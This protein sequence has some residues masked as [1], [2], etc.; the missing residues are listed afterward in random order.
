M[1]LVID[2]RY[3]APVHV[4]FELTTVGMFDSDVLHLRPDPDTPFRE[5]TEAVADRFGTPPYEGRHDEILPHVTVGKAIPR[6]R[7]RHAARALMLAM[8]LRIRCSSVA[9]TS[10]TR[11]S[12]A[13]PASS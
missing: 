6:P 5:L 9:P 7:A 4:G 3:Y 11:P 2:N 13:M 1:A 8:P 12:G 10:F